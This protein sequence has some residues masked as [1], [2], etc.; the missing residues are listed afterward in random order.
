MLPPDP[1]KDHMPEYRAHLIGEDG[2]FYE[3]VPLVCADDGEALEK[4]KRLPDRRDI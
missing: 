3:A 4:A 2:H 1:E